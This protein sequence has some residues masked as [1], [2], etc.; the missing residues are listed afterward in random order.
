[1]SWKAGS[2]VTI[3]MFSGFVGSMAMPCEN[4]SSKIRVHVVPSNLYAPPSPSRKATP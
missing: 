4:R 2:V 3:A 1:M